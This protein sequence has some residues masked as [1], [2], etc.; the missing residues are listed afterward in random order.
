LC[1]GFSPS[2]GKSARGDAGLQK[3]AGPPKRPPAVGL[4]PASGIARPALLDHANP[5]CLDE[6]AIA[7]LA[8]VSAC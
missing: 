7:S 5:H 6:V 4:D 8:F 3:R 2:A 1:L